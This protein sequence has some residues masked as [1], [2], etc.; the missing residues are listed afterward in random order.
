MGDLVPGNAELSEIQDDKVILM[1]GGRYETLRLPRESV[2]GSSG[3]P[4]IS[5]TTAS[6]SD[7]TSTRLQSLRQNL[8]Q[9]PKSLFGLVRP[10][11]KKDAQGKMVGYVLQP[12]REAELFNQ[13]GLEPGDIVTRINDVSLNNVASGMQALRSVQTG[14]TVTMTVLRGDQQKNLTFKIP[15]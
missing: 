6:H 15:E 3:V 9:N 5:A 13:M 14:D 2:T 1:R 8:R 10:I 4:V 7:T 12:G 11:P